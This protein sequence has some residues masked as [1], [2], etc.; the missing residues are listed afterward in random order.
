MLTNFAF[1]PEADANF[2][3]AGLRNTAIT[4]ALTS[5]TVLSDRAFVA[6]D[7]AAELKG[8]FT[9][10]GGDVLSIEFTSARAPRWIALHVKMGEI[11]LL[12]KAAVGVLI[13]SVAPSSTTFRVCLRSG[14]GSGFRD[15][16]FPKYVVSF[17]EQSL[18]LDIVKLSDH[19]DDLPLARTWRELVLFYRP[20]ETN[21]TINDLRLFT[22]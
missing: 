22:I 1:G 2:A 12:D 4:G 3:I 17:A 15:L 18:H 21:L 5:K 7:E 10:G 11:D 8:R 13:K 9:T 19:A 20:E 14:F 16:F 6:F